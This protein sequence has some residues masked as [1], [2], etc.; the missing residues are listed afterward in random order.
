MSSGVK[1]KHIIYHITYEHTSLYRVAHTV[2]THPV[3]GCEPM[4]VMCF[5]YLRM[6]EHLEIYY[7]CS[8]SRIIIMETNIQCKRKKRGERFDVAHQNLNLYAGK[9]D[10]VKCTGTATTTCSIFKMEL[11]AQIK[12]QR[13]T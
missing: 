12:L 6:F 8:M 13:R 11:L 3:L 10:D 5:L 7:I 4:R 1:A 2:D 9:R